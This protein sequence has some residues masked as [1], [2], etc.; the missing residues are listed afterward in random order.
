MKSPG[1]RVK[2]GII[3]CGAIGSRMAEAIVKD[4]RKDC[5]LVGL[6]DTNR[7]K[8]EKLANKLSLKI[9]IDTNLQELIKNCDCMIEATSAKDIRSIVKATLEAKK[10]ILVMSV[11]RLLNCADLFRTARKNKCYILLP[12]GAIAGVDAI[13]AAGLRH[14][15]KITLTTRKPPAGLMHNEY[16]N[17]KGIDLMKIKKETVLFSGS[18]TSAVKKFPQNINVAATIAL[19]A[20][21]KAKKFPFQVRIM[22]SPKYKR[23]IHEIE[24]EGDFGKM[25]SRT[26]NVPC[27]DNPKTSYLAVL[28][29]LQTLKQYCTGILVGT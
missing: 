17:K 3:G 14:L 29:G 24:V 15:K 16:L 21:V 18:V 22:T 6:Y 5:R 1:Y 8:I 11:G 27:P 19:A 4:F 2:I 20:Q 23:N 26:E 10:S 13:K 7:Y 12:S 9:K 25:I 28:S